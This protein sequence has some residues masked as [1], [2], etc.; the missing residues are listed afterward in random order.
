MENQIQLDQIK[1]RNELKQIQRQDIGEMGMDVESQEQLNE[2]NL[3]SK[4]EAQRRGTAL[5]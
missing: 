4:G 3:L 1:L 2:D 5:S